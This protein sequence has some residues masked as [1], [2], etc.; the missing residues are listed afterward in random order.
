MSTTQHVLYRTFLC[1]SSLHN[2]I[3]LNMG[4]IRVEFSLQGVT[5]FMYHQMQFTSALLNAEARTHAWKNVPVTALTFHTEGMDVYNLISVVVVYASQ[6]C[7]VVHY[8]QTRD[9]GL[10]S[11]WWLRPGL[12]AS[13]SRPASGI[14]WR[15]RPRPQELPSILALASASISRPLETQVSQLSI[16]F[17]SAMKM[18][19]LYCHIWFSKTLML[20]NRQN[21][22]D[23]LFLHSV[24][25]KLENPN[26]DC[27]AS[28]SLFGSQAVCRVIR[29]T[30]NNA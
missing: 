1:H 2:G 9:W 25:H 30:L 22:A 14:F 26:N 24:R 21:E 16:Q 10:A 13:V 4:H 8:Y 27:K 20:G 12:V 19:Y 7:T 15:P 17:Y 28:H 5:S 23:K 29:V 6:W 3:V 11:A 18:H